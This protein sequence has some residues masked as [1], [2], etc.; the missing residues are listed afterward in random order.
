MCLKTMLREVIN[1]DDKNQQ[2][3]YL[4]KTYEWFLK[5]Q[6]AVGLVDPEQ[7]AKESDFLNPGQVEAKKKARE[8]EED[9]QRLILMDEIKNQ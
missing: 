9:A 5:Q 1:S 4:K 3:Y 6:T 2:V 7:Q 8:E